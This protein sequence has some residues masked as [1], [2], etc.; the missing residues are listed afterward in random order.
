Q[1]Y[2]NWEAIIV[3]D[4]S[5]DDTD[6]VARKLVASDTSRIKYIP[7][8]NRGVAHARNLAIENSSGEFILPLDAD[9][10]ITPDALGHFASTLARNS[11]SGF[12]ACCVEM[13]GGNPGDPTEWIPGINVPEVFS[14]LNV[15]P[16]TSLWRRAYFDQGVRYRETFYEDWDLWLQI[17]AQGGKVTYIPKKLFRYRLNPKGRD[18][19]NKFFYYQALADQAKANPT[20][21]PAEMRTWAD[22]I[23]ELAPECFKKPTVVFLPSIDSPEFTEFN[24]FLRKI[25]NV[26][27]EQGMLTAPIG[28]YDVRGK[29]VPGVMHLSGRTEIDLEWLCGFMTKIGAELIVF[30]E[31]PPYVTQGLSSLENIHAIVSLHEEFDPNADFNFI[32]RDSDLQLNS[33]ERS[34][35][36]SI[37][38]FPEALELILERFEINK[39]N[40][41]QKTDLHR[42]KLTSL[43]HLDFNELQTGG[44]KSAENR[45]SVVIPCRNVEP[46]RLLRCLQSIRETESPADVEVIVSDFGSR[47]DLLDCYREFSKELS[48]TLIESHTRNRWS[49]SRCLNLAI[50]HCK[51]PWI[52]FTDADMIF[53]P[54]M[55]PMWRRYRDELG[56]DKIYLGQCLKLPPLAHLPNPWKK[57]F[58]SEVA[59]KGRLFDTYG[60]GGCQIIRTDWLNKV[61]GFNEAYEVWG[62]EDLDLSFRAVLDGIKHVWM[63]PGKLLHQWHIKA[64]SS[65]WRTK[66]NDTYRELIRNPKVRVNGES[67]GTISAAEQ[68]EYQSLG[69]LPITANDQLVESN[70]MEQELMSNS[71]DPSKRAE[72]LIDWGNKALEQYHDE[73]ALET[74]EDALTITPSNIE[75]KIGLAKT[76]LLRSA[77]NRA[78]HLA[79]EVLWEDPNHVVA[80]AILDQ[81]LAFQLKPEP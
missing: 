55:F 20:M 26:C 59:D 69:P 45:V 44:K 36:S 4:G 63:Q 68:Q 42:A 60:H 54:S 72:L 22:S 50:R 56:D 3:N 15:A 38:S 57:D 71:H 47:I 17:L 12:A 43:A 41:S 64:V 70:Q 9:D 78:G 1:T 62:A 51:T 19:R 66:N 77:P 6:S 16:I 18:S 49:R 48:V 24:G 75:A 81:S 13:F 79:L 30:S 5:S 11:E 76:Y 61:H 65:E 32:I 52:F 73:A 39:L 37:F 23:L 74:F 46:S 27:I 7:S 29:V 67:W 58:Y 8:E 25:A 33:S 10:M 28:K 80:R 31:L 2:A 34:D 35:I 14:I 53:H 40:H 21:Y